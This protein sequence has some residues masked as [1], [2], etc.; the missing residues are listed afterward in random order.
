[1]QTSFIST[2]AR[3]LVVGLTLA[4]GAIVLVSSSACSVT[5][6]PTCGGN[7]TDCGGDCVDLSSD[8]YDCGGCGITCGAGDYC[9]NGQCVVGTCL[10]DNVACTFD[11][12]CCSLYCAS[13]GLCGCIPSNT[14]G[15]AGDSD[16][17][18][19]FCDLATGVCN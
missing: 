2:P 4:A 9:D 14:S 13:D 15:C 6:T 17:C 12:E 7:L 1:M 5:V 18:S 11:G 19:N 8:P 16:C 3:K 10:G